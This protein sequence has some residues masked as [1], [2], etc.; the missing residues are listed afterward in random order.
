MPSGEFW[1][2]LQ[3]AS[4]GLL[5]QDPSLSW[6]AVAQG[7]GGTDEARCGVF[8]DTVAT[9]PRPFKR[10]HQVLPR[11]GWLSFRQQPHGT[12]PRRVKVNFPRAGTR[13]VPPPR[14]LSW[15]P[16]GAHVA[17]RCLSAAARS[18]GQQGALAAGRLPPRAPSSKGSARYQVGPSGPVCQSP[19]SSNFCKLF[20]IFSSF[21]MLAVSSRQRTSAF[22]C[23]WEPRP[24]GEACSA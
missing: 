12:L 2:H 23:T 11:W 5:A 7:A 24:G 21:T 1:L 16:P 10:V 14:F 8:A 15:R 20:C 19:F 9:E 17:G 22:S 6:K 4:S 13:I 18:S 3:R